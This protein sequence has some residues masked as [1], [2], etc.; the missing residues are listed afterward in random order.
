MMLGPVLGLVNGPVIAD[1]LK[2]PNNRIAKLLKTEKNGKKIVEDIF[3]AILCRLPTAKEMAIGLEA[4]QG[5]K[6]EYAQLLAK[7]KQLVEALNA[8]L[9]GLAARQVQ[10]EKGL[11][12]TPAWTVLNASSFKSSGGATL[13]KEKDG[14]IFASGKNP[15]YETYTL[16]ADTDLSGITAVRLEVMADPRLPAQGPG[17]APNGNF[18]LNEFRLTAAPKGEPNKAVK[19]DLHNAT[20]TFSQVSWAVA[21]AI[22]NNPATGWAVAPQFG[23]THIAIFELKKPLGLPKGATLTFTLEQKF[24]GKFHNIGRFRLS[25]TAAKPPV[26]ISALPDAVAKILAV[27]PDK[28]T[29]PQRDALANYFRSLDRDLPRLQKAV[30]DHVVPVDSRGIGAEDLAWALLN[31]PAFLFNH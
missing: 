12:N 22:D 11:K 2:D 27:A 19:V 31:N 14:S 18:V 24:A 21:G 16:T 17:R 4:I 1:A 29:T 6:Q 30:A 5:N 23:K 20:A 28:R 9:K 3:L 10:W 26:G 7:H 25:V 13:A 8:H 15:E